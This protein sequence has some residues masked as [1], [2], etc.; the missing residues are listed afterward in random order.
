QCGS[1]RSVEADSA[2]TADAL[3]SRSQ[4]VRVHRVRSDEEVWVGRYSDDNPVPDRTFEGSI[5]N[6][7]DRTIVVGIE[8]RGLQS[9]RE[10]RTQLDW[11]HEPRWHDGRCKWV[12]R[13][14]LGHAAITV[15]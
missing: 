15:L 5:E 14:A 9:L 11:P 10:L 13:K 8:A 2:N 6:G 1:L 12:P 4:L 7:K 3:T